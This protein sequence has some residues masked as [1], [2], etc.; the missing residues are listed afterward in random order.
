MAHVPRTK[1]QRDA[2]IRPINSDF[3]SPDIGR[4]LFPALP[5]TSIFRFII[6]LWALLLC[7]SRFTDL[8]PTQIRPYLLYRPLPF[9]TSSKSSFTAP[10]WRRS[11]SAINDR[12]YFLPQR[13][14]LEISHFFRFGISGFSV[15]IS[16]SFSLQQQRR[17]LF[18]FGRSPACR[19][20]FQ[21]C[22][23][24]LDLHSSAYLNPT[25]F[26]LFAITD[27]GLVSYLIYKNEENDNNWI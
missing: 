12:A 27:D 14:V 5:K 10:L 1:R 16:V 4:A 21:I 18:S 23:F 13:Q 17:K 6:F 25:L 19:G 7:C 22:I 11:R 8:L 26:P 20:Y 9:F 2:F 3:L 15:F 24:I